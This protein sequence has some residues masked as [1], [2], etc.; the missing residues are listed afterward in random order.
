MSCCRPAVACSQVPL[1]RCVR[2]CSA[3][4][5]CPSPCCSESRYRQVSGS[6]RLNR[7]AS[8]RPGPSTA[9]TRSAAASSPSAWHCCTVSRRRCCSRSPVTQWCCSAVS[10]CE[11]PPEVRQRLGIQSR[12]TEP[13]R[14][15]VL[16][17]EQPLQPRFSCRIP[18]PAG[19][20]VQVLLQ[21]DD[22]APAQFNGLLMRPVQHQAVQAQQPLQL[23]HRRSEEHTSEL[24]SRG[25]L[26]C[27]L[28]L[29]KK[30]RN[31]T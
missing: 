21:P 3:S 23:R 10:G 30:K 14:L 6:C 2:C 27:R 12:T 5:C 8:Q 13:A 11:Q 25:H 29:E 1:R 15:Q 24:Q 16:D 19:G 17:T 9:S 31:M 22:L 7:R 4:A 20:Q 18:L 26:V 28:L